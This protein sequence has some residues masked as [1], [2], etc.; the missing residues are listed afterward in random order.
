MN[1]DLMYCPNCCKESTISIIEKEETYNVMGVEDITITASV[2]KCNICK[3]EI[4]Y[5]DFDG[6]N[7][8]KDYRVFAK[9]YP[10]IDFPAKKHL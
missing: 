3:R 5:N 10:E 2:C 4:W 7:L 6:E 8:M 9:K 1:Y